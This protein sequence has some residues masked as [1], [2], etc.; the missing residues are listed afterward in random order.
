M[1]E[2][3]LPP[4]RTADE[5]T[6]YEA[7]TYPSL[8]RVRHAGESI[9]EQ[10]AALAQRNPEADAVNRWL[11]MQEL[12]QQHRQQRELEA[13]RLRLYTAESERRR[14]DQ[15]H[16]RIRGASWRAFGIVVFCLAAA[17]VALFL[18]F[19]WVATGFFGATLLAVV[20]EFLTERGQRDG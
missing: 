15:L 1:T 8:G 16:G 3:E 11:A 17:V 14:T 4:A 2:P 7:M 13:D 5:V 20:K 19:P 10:V 12:E 18:E 9:F 6:V